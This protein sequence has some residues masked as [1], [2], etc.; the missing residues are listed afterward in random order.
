M[1]SGFTNWLTNGQ[2][3]GDT[4]NG[5]YTIRGSGPT[6]TVA[7]PSAVQRAAWSAKGQTHWLLPSEDEWY[8]AAYYKSGSINAGYWKY[9]TQSNN[10]PTSQA[11]PGGSN[12]ANY[13]DPRTGYAVT[14][15]KSRETNR[16]YLT[17]VG[18]YPKSLSAYGV[19]DQ[20]GNV[21][22]W[23]EAVYGVGRGL[24]GGSWA[25]NYSFVA[26]FDRVYIGPVDESSDSAGFRVASVP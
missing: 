3:N 5:T 6:W 12:S 24:R 2:Q 17:D 13:F 9:P 14:G 23:N 21:F 4:E 7:V 11:P 22:Q 26:S 10:A 1:R 15:S 18:A 20:G 16:N 25:E 8:K 19:L